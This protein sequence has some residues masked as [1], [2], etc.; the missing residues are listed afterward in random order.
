MPPIRGVKRGPYRKIPS[1]HRLLDGIGP[2]NEKGC[3]LWIMGT[4]QNGYGRI[5]KKLAHRVSFEEFIGPIPYGLFVLHSCDNPPCVNP[6][7]LRLGDQVDNMNDA[8]NRGRL[9]SRLTK[10]QAIEIRNSNESPT[11]LSKK[12]SISRE[13]VY[14]IKSGESWFYV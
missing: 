1:R 3:W 14:R 6:R 8:K 10:E 2:E 4:D 5:D 13:H 11:M 7:H 12:F 9:W